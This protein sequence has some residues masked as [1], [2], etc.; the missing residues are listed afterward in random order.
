[1]TTKDIQAQLP[2]LSTEFEGAAFGDVRLTQRLKLVVDAAAER[3]DASIPEQAVS[4]AAMEAT[5][6][7]LGNERVQYEKILKPH[8]ACTV[9]RCADAK[10]VLAIHDSTAFEFDSESE[11]RD[12]LG[13]LTPSRRGFIGHFALA[14]SSEGARRPLGLLGLGTVFRPAFKPGD[15]KKKAKSASNELNGEAKRWRDLALETA[16]RI[17]PVADLIHVM[18]READAYPLLASLVEAGQR[19]VIRIQHNRTISLENEGLNSAVKLFDTLEQSQGVIERTVDLSKRKSRPE[20]TARKKHPPREGRLARLH[21]SAI[22]ATLLNPQRTTLPRLALNVVRVWEPEP[23]DGQDPIEWRLITT[24]PI[25]TPAD[26]LKIVDWYRARWV[27]EEFFKALKTGCAYQ[28]RQLESKHAMLNALAVLAPVAWRLLLIRTVA[29]TAPDAPASEAFT[30]VQVR[31]LTFLNKK[32]DLKVKLSKQ[33]TASQAMMVVAEL[34]G[35]IKYNGPPGWAVL[36]RGL[37]QLLL[38]ELG[39]AARDNQR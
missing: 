10:L 36:G 38:A 16:E 19:F 4:D 15:K 37:E 23:P 39:W 8:I 24:E 13:W 28:K 31:I 21:F 20:P 25:D 18:D 5:Y 17:S 9:R 33:P 32:L 2:P 26:I 30:D 27:I 1:M 7:F 11:I 14:V 3:P 34:G 12:E 6:R 22:E 35:H 29:R